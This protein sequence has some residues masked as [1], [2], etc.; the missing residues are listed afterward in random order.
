MPALSSDITR[1]SG[2]V[3]ILAQGGNNISRLSPGK[4]CTCPPFLSLVAIVVAALSFMALGLCMPSDVLAQQCFRTIESEFGAVANSGT[5]SP[6]QFVFISPMTCP[7]QDPLGLDRLPH[8][9]R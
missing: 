8:W 1:R 2:L 9:A 6:S 5:V 4:R 3:G 7:S